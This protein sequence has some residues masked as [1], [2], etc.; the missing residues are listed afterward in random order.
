MRQ[1]LS[2]DIEVIATKKDGTQLRTPITTTDAMFITGQFVVTASQAPPAP[3]S[4]KPDP[5]PG[6]H[7]AI[8]PIGLIFYSTYMVIGVS[9]VMYG[10]YISEN[11]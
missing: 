9:I 7:I 8:M 10:K 1:I 2:P 11:F 5:F 4:A 3:S 6:I